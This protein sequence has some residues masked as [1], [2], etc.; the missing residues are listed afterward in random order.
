MQ[1]DSQDD[2]RRELMRQAN[3]KYVLRNYM[4]QIAI[5]KAQQK[6]FSEVNGLL[7]LL[8]DPFAEHP[9]MEHYAGEPPQW[10]NDI[11]VSCSS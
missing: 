8:R 9:H 4:A 1:E 2:V 11:E 3:P 5:D 7:E 10:A 6:D